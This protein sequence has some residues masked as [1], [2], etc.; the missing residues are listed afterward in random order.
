MNY[1]ELNI[2]IAPE[3]AEILT[4][5]LGEIGFESFVDTENGFNAYILENQLVMD[6][7]Q[8]IEAQYQDL[9]SFE[10]Q[11]Q[12]IEQK[13]WNAI[14]ESE[15]EP[16]IVNDKCLIY[17][18]FHQITKKYP[19]EILIN[20]KMSFGTGHHETTTL[21]IEHQLETDHQNQAVLDAG[22]GTGV[23]AIMASK[24]GANQ[25]D[26]IDID[27]W[28]V[29]NTL[30]NIALNNCSYI[31]VYQSDLQNAPLTEKYDII[32]ANIN[33]NVLL[34]EIKLYRQYLT[35]NGVLLLSGFYEI[36]IVDICQET[37]KYGFELIATKQK[38][39]WVSLKFVG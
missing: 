7:L 14:W 5:E 31:K 11:T 29:T 3:F 22:C 28:A 39:Q 19:Y 8:A 18:T 6:D 27:E 36:D 34:E 24:L 17:S 13:N 15:Y 32:L 16:V 4:A 33:K 25:I 30:E 37:Q 21:M 26:A 1:L 12:I 2:K 35:P 10:Y 23:L 38:N 20:P 9:F